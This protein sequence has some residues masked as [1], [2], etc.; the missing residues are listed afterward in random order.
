MSI[1]K[2]K[3]I[4]EYVEAKASADR[5]KKL[6]NS[7]RIKIVDEFFPV[8]GEGT[9]NSCFKNMDLKVTVRYNYKFDKDELALVE[10]MLNDEEAACIKRNPTLDL[11]KFKSLAPGDKVM[12]EDA[13]IITPG[14]P[15]L[16][17][18]EA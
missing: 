10:P 16:T 4:A 7:L 6:E 3:L 1:S 12:I 11:T 5:F 18:K 13:I 14:L 15:T 2:S 17:I 8:A 9:H